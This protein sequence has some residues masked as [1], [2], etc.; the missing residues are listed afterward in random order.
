MI[1]LE[2]TLWRTETRFDP[3]LMDQT[4]SLDFVEFGRSGRRYERTEMIFQADQK[5]EINAVL[6][7]PDY[8]VQ[9]VAVGVALANYTSEVWYADKIEAGR[10]SSLWVKES[11][12]WKLRFHQGT[13][14]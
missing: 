9:L 4:F 10:R 14:C 6:P 12:R 3:V 13:P 2:E 7:L 8:S 11:G 1:A 5:T